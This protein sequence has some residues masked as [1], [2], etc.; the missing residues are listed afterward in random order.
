MQRFLVAVLLGIV[1]SAAIY[2]LQLAVEPS[3]GVRWS[4]QVSI[5]HG[6]CK[7]IEAVLPGFLAGWVARRRGFAAGILVGVGSAIVYP[8]VA[9]PV[10]GFSPLRV[11]LIYGAVSAVLNAITQSIGG[12]AGAACSRERA[13]L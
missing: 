4:L 7:A 9:Y 2:A 5:F 13:I 1:L 8:L 10:W 6:F 11:V 3:A 12:I